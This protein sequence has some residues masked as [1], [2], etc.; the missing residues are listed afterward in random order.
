MLAPPTPG[1]DV[2]K[3]GISRPSKDTWKVPPRLGMESLKESLKLKQDLKIMPAAH[4]KS[5]LWVVNDSDMECVP[6]YF[7]LERTSRFVGHVSASVIATRISE[8][9]QKRSISV[10]FDDEIKSK[11]KCISPEFVD[12][13]VRLFSGKDSFSHGVI[14]EVQ[15][16][17]G[18]SYHFHRIC[19]AILDASKNCAS[20]ILPAPALKRP[21]DLIKNEDIEKGA[22]GDAM[23]ALEITSDLLQKDRIDANL[24]GME[25]LEALTDP[26]K[27][28]AAMA[29]TASK[30]I[31]CEA[32]KSE[33]RDA[34]ASLVQFGIMSLDDDEETC[35]QEDRLRKELRSRALIVLSNALRVVAQ[36]GF[37]KSALRKQAWFVDQLI[38][39]LVDEIREAKRSPHDAFSATKCLNTLF[40]FSEEARQKAVSLGAMD[41]IT[42]A[43]D[44]G[45]L[46]HAFLAG[47]AKLSVSVLECSC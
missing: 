11:A 3:L 33:I 21:V 14:V 20:T 7:V 35:A 37:L 6:D 40:S 13:R 45:V 29:L 30:S 16:R 23:R 15:R 44:F 10:Q 38:P 27:T 26:L 8:C 32:E 1:I 42:E 24:L 31:I 46:T 28:S 39:I 19:R 2:V 41:I 17:G 34:I 47:E 22:H 4:T 5:P 12:F 36:G 18:S 43:R 25:S 9:F